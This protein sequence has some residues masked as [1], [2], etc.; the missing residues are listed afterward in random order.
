[1][2]GNYLDVEKINPSK[3]NTKF[4]ERKGGCGIS[5]CLDLTN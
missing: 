2:I 5:D 1:V 4:Y 3:S